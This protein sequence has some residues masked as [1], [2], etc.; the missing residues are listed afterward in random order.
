MMM[1]LILDYDEPVRA[2]PFSKGASVVATCLAIGARAGIGRA[3]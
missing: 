1:Q 3:K 2:P